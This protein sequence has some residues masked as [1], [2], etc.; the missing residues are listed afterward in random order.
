MLRSRSRRA[1]DDHAAADVQH[2]ALGGVDG[3]GGRLDLAQVRRPCAACSRAGASR[4]AGL[5]RRLGDAWR[6][7]RC[8][9]AP[10]PA[11]RCGRCGTPRGSR[12]PGPR[13]CLT[14]QL[15]LVIGRVMPVMSASWKASLPIRW[16]LTCPVKATI[17]TE[18]MWAVARPVTRLVA[19]GP[20]GGQAHAD[21]AGG[22]GVAV[23]HVGGAL[24][25][26]GQDEADGRVVEHVEDRHDGRPGVA[27]DHLHALLAQAAL[28]GRGLRTGRPWRCP[29]GRPMRVCWQ[30]PIS[31][32]LRYS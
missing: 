6:R 20:A 21:L 8:P 27:E 28:P 1:G 32:R 23:G 17:G 29:T 19:P 26:A 9:P 30:I 12:G 5:G 4:S 3:L 11:G 14:R 25:V 16:L 10:A 18:S 2:R 15:C 13:P 7:R 22:A 31:L 24:L